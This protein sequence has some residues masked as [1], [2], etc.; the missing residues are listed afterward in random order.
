M[1]K[2]VIDIDGAEVL[3]IARGIASARFRGVARD[4]RDDL[5]SEG[6]VAILE[7][8]GRY[9]A[10]SG[11]KFSTYAWACAE[12]KMV[13]YYVREAKRLGVEAEDFFETNCDL[14]YDGEYDVFNELKN[15]EL[16]EKMMGCVGR[17]RSVG[18]KRKILFHLLEGE[19]MSG[20][21]EQL[22]LSR[23]WVYKLFNQI[24][25][26]MLHKY[27]YKNGELKEVENEKAD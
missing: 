14:S 5:V 7:A 3:A 13:E 8:R 23:Q 25:E 12:K 19:K 16:L 6:V 4:I 1:E 20:I 17:G 26:E 2:M 18:V 9:S 21:A 22:G 27:T 11:V 24:K 10:E 15:A